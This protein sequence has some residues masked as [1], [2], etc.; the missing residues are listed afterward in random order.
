MK[1]E[2]TTKQKIKH[3]ERSIRKFGDPNQ[4]KIPALKK[5]EDENDKRNSVN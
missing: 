5:L 3:L 2:L 1:K 4:V